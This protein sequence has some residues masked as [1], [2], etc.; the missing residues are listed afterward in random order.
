VEGG[1]RGGG[2]GG[3][4]RGDGGGMGLRRMKMLEQKPRTQSHT[5]HDV[6]CSCFLSFSSLDQSQRTIDLTVRPRSLCDGTTE[7]S[8]RVGANRAVT[9]G[10]ELC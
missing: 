1:R 2:E 5:L 6:Y 3:G 7:G 9:H 8:S 10:P 4:R